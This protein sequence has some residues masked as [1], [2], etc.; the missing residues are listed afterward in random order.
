VDSPGDGEQVWHIVF[1]RTN[2]K[3]WIFRWINKDFQHCY[4]VKESLG[5]MFW[6]VING[7]RS[8]LDVETYSKDYY[9]RIS[10]MTNESDIIL[11]VVAGYDISLNN[12]Q[13]SIISCSDVVKRC[14]GVTDWLC[15]TPY[16]LYR[17]IK[18][19]KYEQRIKARGESRKEG[20]A[21][22]GA[23]TAG[24]EIERESQSG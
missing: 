1:G 7:R 10:D 5:G 16:Q 14:L 4:A 22:A 6:I 13:L 12:A 8:H 24:A 2:Y 17:N 3:H 23:D 9:S 11:T 18:R 20:G 19:G 21:R 15:W